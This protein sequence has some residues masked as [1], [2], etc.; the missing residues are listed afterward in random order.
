MR[1]VDFLNGPVLTNFFQTLSKKKT[2]FCQKN[3]IARFFWVSW[4]AWEN[5]LRLNKYGVQLNTLKTANTFFSNPRT[6][7][8][9]KIGIN[10]F[11]S[12]HHCKYS[13]TF[14]YS[15]HCNRNQISKWCPAH[16]R[17]NLDFI[18]SLLAQKLHDL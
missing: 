9:W 11:P 7:N 10:G 3:V 18:L 5:S 4:N 12:K 16:R 2:N 6:V 1:F 14:L 17:K 13:I 8:Y 15:I